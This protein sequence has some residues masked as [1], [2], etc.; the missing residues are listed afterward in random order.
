MRVVLGALL[1]AS[2]VASFADSDLEK[3]NYFGFQYSKLT[4]E[5]DLG[6]FEP[7]AVQFNL[8]RRFNPYVAIEGRL[9]FR[10]SE[11]EKTVNGVEYTIQPVTLLAAYLKVGL[12]DS[13][14]VRPYLLVGH[15]SATAKRKTEVNFFRNISDS[16]T[17]T[18]SDPSYGGGIAFNVSP[19]VSLHGEWVM[20]DDDDGFDLT[21][22]NL[23]FHRR[24]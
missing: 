18:A 22:F 12:D 15:S 16:E 8:G 7:T 13:L 24:Y 1:L 23:G 9:G 4:Q 17:V 5:S 11:D 21:A 10:L 6:D 3:R 14:P 19:D 2:S 20:L